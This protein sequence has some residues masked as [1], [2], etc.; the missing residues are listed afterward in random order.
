MKLND[1]VEKSNDNLNIYVNH[2]EKIFEK[3]AE[4]ENWELQEQ[5]SR[6]NSPN[7]VNETQIVVKESENVF[8]CKCIDDKDVKSDS[9]EFSRALDYV[10]DR[11]KNRIIECRDALSQSQCELLLLICDDC[12]YM[13]HKCTE[14]DELSY[15]IVEEGKVNYFEKKLNKSLL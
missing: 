8:V 5:V 14:S 10:G 12:Y 4:S 2:F 15:Y 1:K 9:W 13:K 6:F 11:L 7:E 3:Q